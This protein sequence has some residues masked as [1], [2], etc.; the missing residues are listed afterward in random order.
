MEPIAGVNFSQAVVNEQNV[1]SNW[2]WSFTQNI[3][4][5]LFN[6]I[7]IIGIIIIKK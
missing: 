6:V 3:I 2:L 5:R 7:H 1:N 4:E